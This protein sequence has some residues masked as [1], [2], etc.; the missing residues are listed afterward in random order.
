VG[1]GVIHWLSSIDYCSLRSA[2]TTPVSP[3]QK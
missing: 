3:S 1:N 2:T